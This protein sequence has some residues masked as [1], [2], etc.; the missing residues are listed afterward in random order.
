MALTETDLFNAVLAGGMGF[1]EEW[2]LEGSDVKYI[3]INLYLMGSYISWYFW[4]YING[5]CP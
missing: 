5:Q 2:K 4:S 3:L 1:V